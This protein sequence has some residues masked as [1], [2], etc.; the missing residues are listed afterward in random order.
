M[1]P[2]ETPER[3]AGES[4]T[5][6]LERY[7]RAQRAFKASRSR[8]EDVPVDVTATADA[9]QLDDHIWLRLAAKTADDRSAIEALPDDQR[10]YY[11]TRVFEWELGS[12]GPQGYAEWHSEL[13]S[14]VAA[15]YRHLGLPGAAAAFDALWTSQVMNRLVCS[16]DAE[17]TDGERASL[18]EL[19]DVV[20]QHDTAR[21]AF[22]RAHPDSFS[23]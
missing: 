23:G 19:A 5:D 6:W 4:M 21:I 12:G 3:E 10:A 8:P 7:D 11:V 2:F 9:S 14:F 13:G 16:P 15:G 1:E 20:G 18:W 17:L 22:V